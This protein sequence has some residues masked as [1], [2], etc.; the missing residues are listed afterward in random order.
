MSK[1]YR[2]NEKVYHYKGKAYNT[3]QEVAEVANTSIDQVR[4]FIRLGLSLNDLG[5]QRK[6][7]FKKDEALVNIKLKGKIYKN[8]DEIAK[9]LHCSALTV[10]KYIKRREAGLPVEDIWLE[11]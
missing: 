11:D 3:P 9:E 7:K 4:K 10:R 1:G 6:R 2:S 5:P 8:I